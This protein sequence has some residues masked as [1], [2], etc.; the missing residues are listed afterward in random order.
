MGYTLIAMGL[1]RCCFVCI[2]HS[3]LKDAVPPLLLAGTVLWGEL[4]SWFNLML[5]TL[6]P[7]AH[8]PGV[9]VGHLIELCLDIT[10][11]LFFCLALYPGHIL[12]LES[13]VVVCYQ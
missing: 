7:Q 6:S 10:S 9:L 4:V 8:M 12:N 11:S 5:L 1:S 13:L 2:C 3:L